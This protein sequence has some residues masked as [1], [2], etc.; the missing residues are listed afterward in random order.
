MAD[1]FKGH[2]KSPA[3]PWSDDG[4]EREQNRRRTEKRPSRDR[5]ALDEKTLMNG[6]KKK[7][8]LARQFFS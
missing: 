5:G 2:K 8:S 7:K 3:I 6:Q 4:K 1:S